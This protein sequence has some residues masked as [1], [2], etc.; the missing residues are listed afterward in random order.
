MVKASKEISA[1]GAADQL[2]EEEEYAEAEGDAHSDSEPEQ[3]SP[4]ENKHQ[5]EIDELEAKLDDLQAELD[6]SDDEFERRL[7]KRLEQEIKA[8]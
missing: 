3:L 5:E 1:D 4:L 7:L 6:L 2:E 8:N